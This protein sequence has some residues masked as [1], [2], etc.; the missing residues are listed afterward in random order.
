MAEVP[1]SESGMPS[2][3]L[4]N[5]T[6]RMPPRA[7]ITLPMTSPPQRAR[8]KLYPSFRGWWIV[9]VSFLA[10]FTHGAATSYLFGLLVVPME[11]DLGW[12]RTTLVGALTVATFVSA[13][14]GLF[15]GPLFDRRGAR[16]GMTL[17]ALFGGACLIGLAFVGAPWQFYLLLGVGVGAARTGLEVIGPRTAIANWFVRRRAAAFAWSSGGRAAFGFTMVPVFAILIEQTSWRAGWAV[18]GVVELVVLAPLAW[19][20]VRRRP[21]DYGQLPDGNQ[22]VQA[23][24]PEAHAAQV[25]P[26][27]RPPLSGAGTQTEESWTLREAVRTRTLWLIVISLMLTGFPATGVIANMVPYFIDEGLSLSFASSAFAFFGFGAMFGRPFWGYLAGR[28]G[29]HTSLTL[30]GFAYS[31]VIALYVLASTP[32][33]LFAAA[34]PIGLVTGGSQQLQSQAWP[35]YFGRRHVGSITGL[36]VLLVTPSMALGPLVAA[37]AFDLMGSYIPV[38]SAYAVG[39]FIAGFFFFLARRPVRL[40][41]RPVRR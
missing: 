8:P 37:A 13:G 29:V 9:G 41:R 24:Q 20:I 2:V 21:E 11:N 16:L 31:L 25:S 6:P 30:W 5:A 14:L 33:T 18:L 7:T 34:W 28:F 10:L 23:R 39:A 36:T 19:L 3:K 12:S 35:D 1:R 27:P 17:S 15:L 4:V 32:A 22:R 38:L 40:A 26:A